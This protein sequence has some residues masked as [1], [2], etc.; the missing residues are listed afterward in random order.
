MLGLM[1]EIENYQWKFLQTPPNPRST[2]PLQCC[3]EVDRLHWQIKDRRSIPEEVVHYIFQ[4]QS[5]D[6]TAEMQAEQ[7]IRLDL[8][9]LLKFSGC[10]THRSVDQFTWI[11]FVDY[12]AVSRKCLCHFRR[13]EN[14]LVSSPRP[15]PAGDQGIFQL[16]QINYCETVTTTRVTAVNY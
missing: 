2:D 13:C 10:Y 7:N 12:A 14:A 1:I 6:M 11:W 8:V 5:S 4:L 9:G 16:S 3:K 15:P